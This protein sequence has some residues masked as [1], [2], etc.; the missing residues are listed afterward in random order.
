MSAVESSDEKR[1]KAEK[2]V[3]SIKAA[4]ELLEKYWGHTQ[5]SVTH[6]R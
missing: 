5:S 6:V 2:P 4:L 3:V 1:R